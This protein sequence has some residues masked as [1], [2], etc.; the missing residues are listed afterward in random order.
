LAIAFCDSFSFL[1][2]FL[3]MCFHPT[4]PTCPT[5]P[6]GPN[7]FFLGSFLTFNKH[8]YLPTI[9]RCSAWKLPFR[10]QRLGMFWSDTTG[11]H[12]K[13][14]QHPHLV[15]SL[16]IFECLPKTATGISKEQDSDG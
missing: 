6:S 1:F 2:P 14:S 16:R 11:A 15:I 3:S 10:T 5:W 4:R 8:Y 9:S 12:N 13:L 7:H